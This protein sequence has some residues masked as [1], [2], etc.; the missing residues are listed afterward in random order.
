M[1]SP[2][3]AGFVIAN[4][5]IDPALGEKTSVP[6]WRGL[7]LGDVGWGLGKGNSRNS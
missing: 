7:G 1:T 5:P 3:V 6:R 4:V 2:D